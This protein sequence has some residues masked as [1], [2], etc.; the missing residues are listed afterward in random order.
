MTKL[1]VD[2]VDGISTVF[3]GIDNGRAIV[4]THQ[5]VEPIIERNKKLANEGKGITKDK[6]MKHV[7]SIPLNVLQMWMEQDGVNIFRLHA[8][9]RA[10]YVKKKLRDPLWAYLR[11]SEGSF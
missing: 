7:A 4:S 6:A 1:L 9:E 10:A 3:H 8:K 2:S 5:D 11:T